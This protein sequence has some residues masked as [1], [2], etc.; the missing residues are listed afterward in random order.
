M[1]RW[2]E[3]HNYVSWIVSFLIAIGIF[4]VSSLTFQT[5]LGSGGGIGF[6]ALLYHLIAFFLLAFF[7]TISLVKGKSP[8]YAPIAIILAILYGISDEFHQSFVPGRVPSFF[9]LFL[10]AF[11]IILAVTIYLITLTLRKD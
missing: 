5:Q 7:L 8:Q 6:R 4:Y 2:L 1:I 9:D 3:K 11:G 10:N